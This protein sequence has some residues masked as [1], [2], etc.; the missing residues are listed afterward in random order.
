MLKLFLYLVVSGFAALVN[1][2]SRFLYDIFFDFWLSVVF[3]YFTGMFV[4]YALSKKYVFQ[5]YDGAQT[6]K[7]ISKFAFVAFMGLVVTT[8]SSVIA[9]ELLGDIFEARYAEPLAHCLGIGAAFFA[10]FLGHNFFTFRETGISRFWRR[11]KK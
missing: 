10:S 9:L 4:N 1:F 7:T 3:A 2:A 8:A 11:H 6:R 5:S